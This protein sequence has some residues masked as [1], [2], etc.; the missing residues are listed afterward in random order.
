ML[1]LKLWMRLNMAVTLLQ[2]LQGRLSLY[3]RLRC[4]DLLARASWQVCAVNTLRRGHSPF[5]VLVHVL[6]YYVSCLVA[7]LFTL[8][9]IHLR[10][11]VPVPW[12]KPCVSSFQKKSELA[13]CKQHCKAVDGAC[14]SAALGPLLIVFSEACCIVACLPCALCTAGIVLSF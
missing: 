11:V 1:W 12:T 5:H 8:H 4:V 7:A 9:V 10:E 14:T 2:L 6:V 13:G 3:T